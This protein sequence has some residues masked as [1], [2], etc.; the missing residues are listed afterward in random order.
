VSLLQAQQAQQ[1]CLAN[2]LM[3]LASVQ[4]NQLAVLV[5]VAL[6]AK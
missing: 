4:L 3:M 5:T 1:D 2:Q 6:F